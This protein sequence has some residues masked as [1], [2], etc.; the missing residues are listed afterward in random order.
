[1]DIHKK[2]INWFR[3]KKERVGFLLVAP[4]VILVIVAFIKLFIDLAISLGLKH[5]LLITGILVLIGLFI[6]G[7][8]IL[9]NY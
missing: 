3:Y 5:C 8:A 1:V 2:I 4:L 6:K 7:I 9:E